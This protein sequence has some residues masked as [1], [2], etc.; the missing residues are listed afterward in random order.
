MKLPAIFKPSHSLAAKLTLWVTAT[1]LVIFV[2]ITLFIYKTT[3]DG[4]FF[5]ANARY[6]GLLDKNNEHVNATL[7]TAEVAV[8]NSVPLVEESLSQPDR[9]Y[10][11]V[12]RVLALNPDIVGSAVAFEPGYFIEK[13]LQFSP[14]AYREGDSIM[15]KQLGTADYDYHQMEWYVAPK[16]LAA[17][18]WSE[19]YFDANGGNTM[20]TTYSQPLFNSRGEFYAVF[21]ADIALE[22]LSR[23][24]RQTDSINGAAYANMPGRGNTTGSAYSF[25]I[26]R[27]GT[28]IAHPNRER[29]LNES[30][31]TRCQ[32]TPDTLDDHIGREM[33]AGLRGNGHLDVQGD[34]SV[35]YAPIERT[36]WSMAIV[37]PDHEIV[38]S[39]QHV[40]LMVIGL[41]LLG[42]LIVFL[43]CH[44][45]IGRMTKPLTRFAAS[46]DEIAQGNFE[47][48]LPAVDTRDEMRHLHDSFLT[49]QQSLNEQIRET[50]RVTEQKGRIESELHIARAIQMAMLPK[51]F[52]PFP[53]LDEIA[54]YGQLTPAKAVGGDLYDFYIRDEKLFFCIGDV[55]GKG[56]PASLVMA[57]TRALFRT[58]SA[59]VSSPELIV[60]QLSNTIA[61][62]NEANMFVTLFV[63]VLDLSSGIMHYCNAGHDAPLLISKN[64]RRVGLLPVDSNL[65]AGV[66]PGWQFSRQETTIDSGTTIF[67]YTDGLTEAEDASHGQF[68]EQR[69]F[70]KAQAAMATGCHTPAKLVEQMTEA[71]HAFV[72]NAEQSDDLT[73]MAILYTPSHTDDRPGIRH[74]LTLPNDVTTISQLHEYI[75]N[76]AQDAGLDKSMAMSL[77]LAIEEAVVNVMNYAYPHD[78]KGTVN[79]VTMVDD[80]WLSFVISDSGMPFDPTAA[81]LADITLTASE[82]PIGGLGIFLVRQLM[83]FVGYERKDGKNILTVKKKLK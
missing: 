78:S 81:E 40:G 13:G 35:Y 23:M 47:A 74:S 20:M 2:I 32:Q 43:V 22:W 68:G 8:A 80:E 55:S 42:L 64:G 38:G 50:V 61:E 12:E 31:I 41:M 57:V 53:D 62:D 70:D 34:T 45:A 17:P 82:R 72:G 49:M 11:V 52:P 77:D 44:F 3:A 9:L 19:P 60:S 65:P 33:T 76:I 28:F 59:H 37:V 71:V 58:I 56:V 14:Y 21:T 79:I 16:Q 39:A 29:V 24:M 46:A 36:G 30:F 48:P 54:I 25:I 6:M 83:D 27:S 18:Y 26:G 67:L 1:M 15:S 51:I 4:I 75:D 10:D 5:E 73:M 63:G 66:M 69:L 7:K